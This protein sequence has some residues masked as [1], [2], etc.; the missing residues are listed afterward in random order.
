MHLYKSDTVI[1]RRTKEASQA[2][3]RCV[4]VEADHFNHTHCVNVHLRVARK[5]GEKEACT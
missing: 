5:T 4:K 2:Q 1:F 3:K